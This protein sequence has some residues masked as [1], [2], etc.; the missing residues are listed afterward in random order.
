MC[1]RSWPCS[2][3][4][5]SSINF[6]LANWSI[7]CFSMTLTT[8]QGCELCRLLLRMLQPLL[9]RRMPGHLPF[10]PSNA[11]V[12]PSRGARITD[13]SLSQALWVH[14]RALT[15]QPQ[16]QPCMYSQQ[17]SCPLSCFQPCASGRLYGGMGPPHRTDQSF[18]YWF[19]SWLKEYKV[20]SFFV[21]C[22]S[23]FP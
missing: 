17:N 20:E 16:R 22:P 1:V 11:W 21:R 8:N 19:Q 10:T 4:A 12:E 13:R 3:S 18:R 7:S 9:L 5:K 15:S 2:F 6:Q 23:R 14:L